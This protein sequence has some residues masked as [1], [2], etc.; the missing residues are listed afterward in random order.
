M[1]HRTEVGSE[2]KCDYSYSVITDPNVKKI[3]NTE[4]KVV[5]K[6]KARRY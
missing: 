5:Y 4:E 1:R 6:Q 3:K 2:K